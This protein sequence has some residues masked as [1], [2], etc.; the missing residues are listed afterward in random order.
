MD[1]AAGTLAEFQFA[2]R[3]L[4]SFRHA[5]QAAASGRTGLR[6]AG[7]VVLDNCPDFGVDRSNRHATPSGAAVSDHVGQGFLND[8]VEGQRRHLV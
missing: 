5:E 6:Q 3:H 7:A 4:Q 8:P 2:A 1:A